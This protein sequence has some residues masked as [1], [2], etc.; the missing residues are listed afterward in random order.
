MNS[1]LPKVIKKSL[2]TAAICSVSHYAMAAYIESAVG[3]AVAYDATGV[4]YNPASMVL[5]HSPQFVTQA[6]TATVFTQFKG[7]ETQVATHYS[8]TGTAD[9]RSNY[10]LPG[11]FYAMP[12]TDRVTM[13]IGE[14]YVDYGNVNYPADSIVR[15]VGT[16]GNVSV[17]DITPAVAVKI[18]DKSAVGFGLD[19]ERFSQT[20]DSMKGFPTLHFSDIKSDNTAT[21]WSAGA[22]AGVLFQP[23]LGTKFGITYHTSVHFDASG[24]STLYTQPTATNSN[25]YYFSVV[26]P[27]STVISLDQFFTPR[28]G[29]MTTLERM[30]WSSIKNVTQHNPVALVA[31]GKAVVPVVVPTVTVPY[32][33]HD[34]WRAGVG[35]H[36][37]ATPKLLTRLGVAYDEDPNNTSVQ[38]STSPGADAIITMLGATYKFTKALT[39]DVRYAHYFYKNKNIDTTLV[40]SNQNGSL[41]ETRDVIESSLVVGFM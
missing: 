8:Q 41:H 7:T 40:G 11:L 22:H 25:D 4:Y 19:A 26:A 35:F 17:L 1:N 37:L 21:A 20:L 31:V 28:L 18:T 29:M 3:N 14:L 24:K 5:V 13:G 32:Y 10:F 6:I 12:V 15:Y 36:Y 23:A 34:T 38:T 33:F 2:L 16:H 9:S 30:Q 27:P 39:L